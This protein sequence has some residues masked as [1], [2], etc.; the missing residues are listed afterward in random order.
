MKKIIILLLGILLQP[1]FSMA[2]AVSA[3]EG[4][5]LVKTIE[6]EK[7]Y[8]HYNSSLLFAGE[9][10]YYKFYNL[11]SKTENLSDLSQVAYLELIGEDGN[12]IFKHKILLS[13]GE[14]QGDFFIPTD[15][16]SGKYKLIG[17]TNWMRNR[18]T[19]FAGNIAVINPYRGD[20][21]AFHKAPKN[22]SLS[23]K[24]SEKFSSTSGAFSAQT[25]K[26]IEIDLQ[27]TNFGKRERV[28]LDL[29][30]VPGNYSLSV[31]IKDTIAIPAK[32]TAVNFQDNINLRNK[33][34]DSVYLPELRGNLLSGR[35][36]PKAS[37][38]NLRLAG[39]KVA[40]SIP[41]ENYIFKIATTDKQGRFYVNLDEQY[42]NPDALMQ[43][44][45]ES[46]EHFDIK[47]DPAPK[48]ELPALNF[49]D[50]FI[51]PDLEDW[52]IDRSVYN[53]IENAY[54]SV[55]PDTIKALEPLEPFY[56]VEPEVYDLDAY[57]RFKT[58][59]ETFVEIIMFSWISN[60]RDKG[61]QIMIR[62]PEG[63][64]NFNIPALLL[65]DGIMV[66]DHD[67]FINYPAHAVQSIKILRNNF[68]LGSHIFAGIIDV[69]TIRGDFWENFNSE[70]VKTI[71]LDMPLPKRYYFKQSYKENL[72]SNERIPD[73]R[74]QLLWEP[75][76]N[77]DSEKNSVEFYTSDVPG[78]YEI[79]LEGFTKEG[80]PVAVKKQFTVLPGE[81]K[82]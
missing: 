70:K 41:G 80:I 78:I 26:L 69:E 29:E 18:G 61:S 40:F 62:Q 10:L 13:N 6:E 12:Y 24:T 17:Y 36:I 22:D 73:F 7:P 38:A 44:I 49:E 77:L 63:A 35:I 57:T 31:R 45:G 5:E 2:Q 15:V 23:Q 59:K 75:S 9:Y 16:P 74:T 76:I 39:K 55:K 27:K 8:I 21:S 81:Q 54:Y 66:Q 42:A 58:I 46:S 25:E 65:V 4:K 11:S 20:Q 33:K 30:E 52:I 68:F 43:I 32:S 1:G 47:P 19:F 64:T 28:V 34:N 53:Q 14:G 50:F 3:S 71:E 56:T 48:M 37:E 79:Q 67:L 60:R 72:S 82:L 51:S